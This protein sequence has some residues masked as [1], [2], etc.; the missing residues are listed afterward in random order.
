MPASQ[1]ATFNLQEFTDAGLLLVGGRLYTY[2]YGTTVQKIAY[3]DPAGTVPH[4]YT[5]D[6]VGGQY[7]ALNS[8][9]ELPAPLYLAAGSYD[10]TLKRGDGSTIWTRKAD[11][12]DNTPNSLASSLTASTGASLLGFTLPGAV[13]RTVQDKLRESPSVKDLGAAGDGVK[14]DTAAFTAMAAA[15]PDGAL[16]PPGTYKIASAVVGKFFSWG[17]VTITGGGSVTS[18]TQIDATGNLGARITPNK[19]LTQLAL[20][21]AV[22]PVV[23]R[24]RAKVLYQSG[25]SV[26]VFM[27]PSLAMAGFRFAGNYLKG[28]V[29]LVPSGVNGSAVIAYPSALGAESSV[30][31]NN[32]YAVFACANAG[33]AAVTFKLMPFLR[34]QSVAGSVATLN[35]AGAGAGAFTPTAATYAFN[36]SLAGVD[37]LV[38]NELQTGLNRFSGRVTTITAN[39]ATTVTLGTIG[40]VGAFDFLLPAPPGFTEYVYLGAFYADGAGNVLNI[41]DTGVHVGSLGSS[42]ADPNYS[43]SGALANKQ[44]RFGGYVSPL[45]MSVTLKVFENISSAATGDFGLDL[46][47]DS[48]AHAVAELYTN[49]EG[50]AGNYGVTHRFDVPF[51]VMQA[52]W[53]STVGSL[54]AS[55]GACS[56]QV[57]GYSEP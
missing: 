35:F 21:S 18:I 1:P 23:G 51:S 31:N 28:R 2:G 26:Q 45:A 53:L 7:I 41:A 9:G 48:S 4:T 19:E 52:V 29:P 10:L 56:L 34:V 49:K 15:F 47:H 33:D 42:T 44:I 38:I 25:T 6:G 36:T 54:A 17:T 40:T 43:A 24:A 39:S 22:S 57:Y 37:C 5:A 30:Q 32:W 55:R 20:A 50:T 8:R 12:V 13:A 16:V 46:A 11:G 3:T 27:P 14:D